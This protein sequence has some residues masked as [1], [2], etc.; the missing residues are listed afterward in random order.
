MEIT[1]QGSFCIGTL[2]SEYISVSV[3]TF[4][5]Q[6]TKLIMNSGH[7]L[8]LLTVPHWPEEIAH[9]V[10]SNNSELDFIYE[11]DVHLV[12]LQTK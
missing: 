12:K 10:G 7:F 4:S 8:Q 2:V 5:A 9:A 11:K 3:M 1:G 6:Y